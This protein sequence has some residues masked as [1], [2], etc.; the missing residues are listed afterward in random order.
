MKFICTALTVMALSCLLVKPAL[1]KDLYYFKQDLTGANLELLEPGD[2]QL[3]IEVI[4]D[5]PVYLYEGGRTVKITGNEY[6]LFDQNQTVIESGTGNKE[7]TISQPGYYEIEAK[8]ISSS[9]KVLETRRIS[10]GILD[11]QSADFY[12]PHPEMPFGLWVGLLK[13]Y[14]LLGVKWTR[15][16]N[17]FLAPVTQQVQALQELKAKNINIIAYAHFPPNLSDP[18]CNK[19]PKD[20]TD[21]QNKIREMIAAGK[22]YVDIW[23]GSINEPNTIIECPGKS[24]LTKNNCCK[25]ESGD[26]DIYHYSSIFKKYVDEL[27]PGKPIIGFCINS[28]RDNHLQMWQRWLGKGFGKLITGIEDH[29]YTN[30]LDNPKNVS[31]ADLKIP[32]QLDFSSYIQRLRDTLKPSGLEQ[33]PLVFSE[34]GT[35]AVAKDQ[36]LYQARYLV[37]LYLESMRQNV[38]AVIWHN[39]YYVEPGKPGYSLFRGND[40]RVTFAQPRPAAVAYGVMTRQLM[41]YQFSQV[42]DKAYLFKNKDGQRV[43]VAWN[44]S[45]PQAIR[46]NPGVKQVRVTETF[47]K[48]S[49][50]TTQNGWLAIT[51][52]PDPIYI[53]E[54]TKANPGHSPSAS[55]TAQ[56]VIT[57]NKFSNFATK[58]KIL[59]IGGGA[60]IFL[61]AVIL[62]CRVSK[63][64]ARADS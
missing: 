14:P 46:L 63:S 11:N 30:H 10:L 44:D 38:K 64:P 36:E 4:D 23:S 8:L 56:P 51:V 33:K 9:G 43:W 28:T 2:D 20:W 19:L 61:A 15:I 52:G 54:N 27:D 48:T 60:T 21:T 39:A 42:V 59:V 45:G 34:A 13:T 41:G 49:V 16:K 26:E 6:Q 50:Q 53:S 47:G 29:P 58:H 12:G 32:E 18:S 57:K 17:E 62:L 35:R 1:A 5:S 7:I 37:N 25:G 3:Q 31:S 24:N 55:F 40:N 22:D